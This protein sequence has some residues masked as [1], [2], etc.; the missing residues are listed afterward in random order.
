M[1]IMSLSKDSK[2]KHTLNFCLYLECI[3][4]VMILNQ[5]FSANICMNS[6]QDLGNYFLTV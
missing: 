3:A 6:I 1:L 5:I 2:K 4:S